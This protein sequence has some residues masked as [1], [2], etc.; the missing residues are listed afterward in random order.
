M[1]PIS[2]ILVKVKMALLGILGYFDN[3]NILLACAI[4]AAILSLVL[5][6]SHN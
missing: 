4:A 1:D 5:I 3:P 2:L 6:L